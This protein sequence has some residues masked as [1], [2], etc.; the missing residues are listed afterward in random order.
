ML[1]YEENKLKAVYPH[2]KNQ[3]RY[4][5][6]PHL[7][8]AIE[9]EDIKDI[10]VSESISE[11]DISRIIS[12]FPEFL[13]EKLTFEDTEVEVEGGRIDVV[14]KTQNDETLLIEIEIE[15]RDNAIGQVQRFKIPYSEKFGIPLEKIRLGI[16][17]AKISDSRITACKGAGIEVYTVCFDK[18]A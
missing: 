2:V 16:V 14:F 11:G 10:V 17:C 3:K 15:A 7:N 4:D 6:I 9:S 8:K 12:T 18:K 1:Q 13:E 5:I